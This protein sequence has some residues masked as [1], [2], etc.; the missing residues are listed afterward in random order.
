[1]RVDDWEEMIDVNPLQAVY[2]GTKNAVRRITEDV[3][4]GEIV[5]RPTAKA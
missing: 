5:V 2:A 4:V 1:L 3:D